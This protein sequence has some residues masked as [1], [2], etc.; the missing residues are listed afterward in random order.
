MSSLQTELLGFVAASTNHLPTCNFSELIISGCVVPFTPRDD[1]QVAADYRD[2]NMISHFICPAYH[3]DR[4]KYKVRGFRGSEMV[5]I[6]TCMKCLLSIY[7]PS[8]GCW[9]KV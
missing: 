4:N 6:A 5:G 9:C 3:A 8:E 7:G 2:F 1:V